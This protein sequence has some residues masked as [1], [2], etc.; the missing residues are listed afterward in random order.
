MLVCA[1]LAVAYFG[2]VGLRLIP[3]AWEIGNRSGEY[4][5]ILLR[6]TKAPLASA[7]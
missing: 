6:E 5:S 4:L 7:R 3:E 2:G 1:G